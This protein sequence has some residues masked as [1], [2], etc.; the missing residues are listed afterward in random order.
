MIL[1]V[2][3]EER[4]YTVY[5]HVCKSNLKTYIGITC[6]SPEIRWGANGCHYHNRYFKTQ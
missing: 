2:A 1:G 3:D 6:R 5:M 4:N